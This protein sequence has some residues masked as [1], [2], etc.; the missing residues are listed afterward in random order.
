MACREGR[1]AEVP[2]VLLRVGFVGETG[3]EIHF[4]AEYGEYLWD[5]LLDTGKDLNLRPFGVETQRLLRLEKK[6]IIVGQD[7][8][9][10]SNPYDSD[11]KWAVK[12]DKP[13][14]VG[15]HAHE[16]MQA[17][18]GENRLVGFQS[19]S[20]AQPADGSAVVINGRLAGRVTSARFSPYLK[21]H[22]G[23]A[24]VPQE[25][26]TAGSQ[27]AFHRDG[28]VHDALVVDNPFYDPDGRRQK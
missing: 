21:R 4:P 10:L 28:A 19:L 20:G 23:L 15:R 12:L 5:V 18:P 22:I 7:T 25:H 2:A 13:D 6:H 8:D 16:R 27:F 14:F 26:S 3:W 9:A 17:Q 24:W 1:V 11:L